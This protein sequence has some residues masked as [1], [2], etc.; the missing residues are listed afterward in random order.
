MFFRICTCGTTGRNASMQR[1]C[2]RIVQRDMQDR[3]TFS[4]ILPEAIRA[5]SLDALGSSLQVLLLLDVRVN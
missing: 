2:S 5:R 1:S 4:R 3:S